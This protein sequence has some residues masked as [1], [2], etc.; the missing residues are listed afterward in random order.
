MLCSP[1]CCQTLNPLQLSQG[2]AARI[3]REV[4]G[5]TEILGLLGSLS[6]SSGSFIKTCVS[7]RAVIGVFVCQETRKRVISGQNILSK[8]G[9]RV[10]DACTRRAEGGK[11]REAQMKGVCLGSIPS[12]EYAGHGSIQ[13]AEAGD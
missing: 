12:A 11:G 13:E 3:I 4:L 7:V 9:N 6:R 1:N 10:S 8:L 2:V 5:G